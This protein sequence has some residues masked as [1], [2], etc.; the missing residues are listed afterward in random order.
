MD[1]SF[2]RGGL[3]FLCLLLLAFLWVARSSYSARLT[4]TLLLYPTD[5]FICVLQLPAFLSLLLYLVILRVYCK[6]NIAYVTN[7]CSVF[8]VL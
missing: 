3:L 1:G 2:A 7:M 6:C 5:T 4:L 8:F